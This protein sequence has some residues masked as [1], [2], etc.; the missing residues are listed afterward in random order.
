MPVGA[1]ALKVE[2]AGFEGY[3]QRGTLEVGNNIQINATLTVGSSSE[4]VEV[5]ATGAA[6]ETETSS[7][8]QVIDQQRITELPL[9]GRQATQLILVSGRSGQCPRER[10]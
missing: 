10:H 6:L 8:K 2:S 4:H 7:F 1:Y 9:N 3:T 5:T